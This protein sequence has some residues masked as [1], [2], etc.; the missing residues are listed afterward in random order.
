MKA[1]LTGLVAALALATP[2]WACTLCHS[3][4]ALGV[5]HLLLEHDL[6]RNAAA[7]AAPIPVLLA[8]ILFAARDP[9]RPAARERKTPPEEIRA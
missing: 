3:P 1:P 7:L 8:A 6:A 9:R 5:R 4:T 2:A